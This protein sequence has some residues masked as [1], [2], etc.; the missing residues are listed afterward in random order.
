MILLVSP[1]TNGRSSMPHPFF[2]QTVEPRRHL[3]PRIAFLLVAA[4]LLVGCDSGGGSNQTPS[5][6]ITSPTNGAEFA[7][8]PTV[9]LKGSADDPEDGSLSGSSLVWKSSIDGQVGKGEQAAYNLSS[10]Q[11]TI[12]LSATDSDGA[13]SRDS[14]SIAVAGP[15]TVEISAPEDE[16]IANDEETFTFEGTAT[17]PIDGDLNQDALEWSSDVDGALGTGTS[18]SNQPLSGGSHTITLSA[19]DQDGN[20]GTASINILVESPGFDARIRFLSDDLTSSQK[21]AIREAVTPWED[22]ITGDLSSVFPGSDFSNVTGIQCPNLEKGIDD[23]VV[24]VDVVNQDGEGGTLASAAPCAARTENGTTLTTSLA[25]TVQIDEPTLSREN[26]KEIITHEIGHVL[27]IGIDLLSG[28]GNN[29]A[30]LDTYDPYH[31]GSETANAFAQLGGEAYLSKGVPLENQ[32]GQ[33]TRGGHWREV[34]TPPDEQKTSFNLGTELMTGFIDPNSDLPLS[35]VTVASLADLGYQ[36]D[37]QAA[38]NF[39]LKMPQRA[40]WVAN[41]DAT[42]SRPDAATENYGTPD[43]ALP[44]GVRLDSA[45]VAGSNNA[46]LWSSNEPESE[47]YSSLIRFGTPSSIPT[48]VTLEE[49]VMNLVVNDRNTETSNHN[50]GIFP[51]ESDWAESS[52]TWDSRP[53]TAQESVASFDFE[54]CSRCSTS[55]TDLARDWAADNGTTNH[56]I[57]LR[58]PD[59]TSDP[60]FSVGYFS[61]HRQNAVQ[62]P[63]ILVLGNTGSMALQT[64][65][66]PSI[67]R[68]RPPSGR[69]IPLGNDILKGP[70][71]G[72]DSDGN[73]VKTKRI[74]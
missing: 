46:Q 54:S 60:T 14:V 2:S 16:T 55:L 64:R 10:G 49:A 31:S 18:L 44:S 71:V 35:R 38:D 56:G 4:G 17:D 66:T 58:A 21:Q 3:L 37:L 12:T 13:T 20:K 43:L 50:I 51:V 70:V 62:R 45:L 41:A 53:S 28:W 48:G 5:V 9:T 33:G 19:T 68:R 29:V 27:G 63:L 40:V 22:V 25:G 52:V 6:S 67:K 24:A 57:A 42:L 65:E 8:D 11:H 15:P 72:V 39:E 32:G 59:A 73:V 30:D 69:K 1:S 74:R 23:L 7:E 34:L 36:V 47:L 61:R 26:L